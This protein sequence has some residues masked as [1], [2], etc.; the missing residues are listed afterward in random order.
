MATTIRREGESIER[1][2][3]VFEKQCASE[4]I[5]AETMR[6]L[7]YETPNERRRRK[8]NYAARKAAKKRR[9]ENKY[10]NH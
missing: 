4:R 6:R 9:K 2:L 5:K 1:L 3:K 10:A 7:Y 8:R